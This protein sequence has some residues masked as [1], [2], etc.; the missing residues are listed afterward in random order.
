[1]RARIQQ[2]R[3]DDRVRTEVQSAFSQGLPIDRIYFP[4]KKLADSE[5]GRAHYRGSAA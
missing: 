3:V 1:M 4:N 2:P 5:S